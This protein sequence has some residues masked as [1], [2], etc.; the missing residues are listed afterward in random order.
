MI[1]S[2]PCSNNIIHV[3]IIRDFYI[4]DLLDEIS[5]LDVLFEM[6]YMLSYA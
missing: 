3:W 5:I 6:Q 4:N 2:S 1:G